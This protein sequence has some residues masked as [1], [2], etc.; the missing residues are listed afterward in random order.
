MAFHMM[1]KMG[2]ALMSSTACDHST[3][4]GRLSI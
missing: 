2:G 4:K 1:G 3:G